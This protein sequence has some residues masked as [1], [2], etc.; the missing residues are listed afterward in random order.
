M[1]QEKPDVLFGKTLAHLQELVSGL[2]LPKFTA[3]QIADW[4]YKKDVTAIDQMSNLSKTV[5]EKLAENF[6]IGLSD[7][8]KVQTSVD[9]TKKYLFRAS[10]GKF[11][12]AAYL[13]ERSRHTLCVSSQVGCKMGCLFCFTAKQGFQ[14]NL[15]AGEIL[16]QIRSLPERHSLTNIVYMG[17]G[18]PFD[19]M[20]GVMQSLEILTA[21]Y[22]IGM[23]PRRITVSTIGI[24]PAMKTFLEQSPCH[25]A[26][27]LHS[28][29]EVERRRLMPIEHVYS[30]TE[31][32][33]AIRSFP[34]GKQRRISFEYI[35]FKDLN[36]SA[37]HVKELA[38]IL[39]GI[40]C[41]INLLRFHPVPGT[42]LAAPDDQ[43]LEDFKEALEKKG[44]VTTIR[45]SRG[46][47]IY[48]ACGLLS[49]K[50][51]QAT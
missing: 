6:D 8:V 28:P 34:L 42:P 32:L 48:A 25:L 36:H 23:S 4:L 50:Q 15:S 1:N 20:E 41:R 11:I 12:E 17:M 40:R 24:I 43:T 7:P 19:N 3:A 29:F 49:T 38:R 44:I 51:Q 22:G 26:V 10:N 47:D 31:V 37:R 35:V 30:L 2:G 9:G 21:D 14:G 46:Q 16:N 27:S 45:K 5:R 33:E 39:N 18:E 13:P